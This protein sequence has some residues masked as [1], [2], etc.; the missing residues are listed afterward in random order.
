VADHNAGPSR[1]LRGTPLA[2]GETR[3]RNGRKSCCSIG[4]SP[5]VADRALVVS[6]SR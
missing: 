1:A 4:M 3:P 2:M 6:H 5:P